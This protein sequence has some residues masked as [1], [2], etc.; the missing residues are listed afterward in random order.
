M[1]TAKNTPNMQNTHISTSSHAPFNWRFLLG[2]V[3]WLVLVAAMIALSLFA[4]VHRQPEPFELT[5]SKD[6]QAIPFPQSIQASMRWLTAVNDPGPDVFIVPAVVIIF[7]LF[8]WFKEAIFLALSAGI[9]NGIDALIGDYVGRPRPSSK[10]IHVDS[11]LKFNSFPSGHSCH[12][13]VFFGFLLYLSF[14]KPVREWKYHW[15]IL[16]LQVYAIINILVVGFAR[17]WEGE[18]WITDVIGGYLD[19][20]IWLLLFI[21]LYNVTAQKLKERRAKRQAVAAA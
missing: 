13:M 14:T 1:Y 9:G 21:F 4:H 11:M 2:S 3:F 10:L 16:P 7:A 18:H 6:I 15:A 8:R 17:L 20:A 12:M 19:G 5:I